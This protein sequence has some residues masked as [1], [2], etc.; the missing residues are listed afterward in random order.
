MRKLRQALV[1]LSTA[2]LLRGVA[3]AAPATPAGAQRDLRQMQ[4]HKVSELGLTIW[5]ENLPPWDT[6]LSSAT[7][8]P[9]FVAQSPEGYHPPAVMTYTSFQKEKVDMTNLGGM[10]SS[11]IQRAS[12]NFGLSI[13]QARN[14]DII[15]VQYGKLSGFES[16]FKGLSN[17]VPMDVVVFVGQAPD[18]F[19]VALS[20][21]T[22]RG[23]MG[24]L[25]EQ[26]R[27]A[28]GKLDYIAR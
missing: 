13:A 1:L 23:K 10:A 16:T 2:V 15:N 22:M 18:R 3:L 19:P 12:Q 11:A 6:Q 28:W 5:V 14:L 9:T 26:R 4:V 20:V 7:G 17:G 8:R 24:S 27:R 21:Y 25:S